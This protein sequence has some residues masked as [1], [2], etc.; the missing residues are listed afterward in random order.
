MKK[1]L[2]LILILF[3]I[4]IFAACSSQTE[5]NEQTEQVSTNV[6]QDTQNA[7]QPTEILEPSSPTE[8]PSIP[9]SFTLALSE[10]FNHRSHDD[11]VETS[12]E[13]VVAYSVM[14]ELDSDKYDTVIE[15]FD[16]STGEKIN[17]LTITES[18]VARSLEHD[19]NTG[20]VQF[21]TI[22]DGACFIYSI[23][24]N[25]NITIHTVP[26]NLLIEEIEQL[27]ESNYAYWQYSQ[28]IFSFDGTP[29]LLES[30]QNNAWWA[31]SNSEGIF[32]QPIE[33]NQNDELFLSNEIINDEYDFAVYEDIPAAH[34]NDVRLMRGGEILVATVVS[35]MAQSGN[36]GIYTLN[37]KTGEEMW[38][39]DIFSAMIASVDY[40]DD[41]TV[42]AF[43]YDFV[44]FIDLNSGETE[45]LQTPEFTFFMTYDFES[46]FDT[47]LENGTENLY[48]T[49]S[50]LGMNRQILKQF[51]TPSIYIM[52]VTE[53][54]V[55]VALD[56]GECV[57]VSY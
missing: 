47:S 11:I 15:F 9:E 16:K 14:S 1:Y 24:S 35:P 12:G 55:F 46:F 41:N 25:Y 17:W 7:K 5:Q 53:N 13:I 27:N 42:V 20:G 51:D 33:G 36:V 57:V 21:K 44:T 3:S 10:K 48:I 4:I 26:E 40:P 30:N 32:V 34:F 23:D 8:Q 28:N 19:K 45:V 52:K 6:E 54:F 18:Y 39:K 2:C 22:G 38:Y 31:V 56:N 49:N 29:E 50:S 37:I 43:G